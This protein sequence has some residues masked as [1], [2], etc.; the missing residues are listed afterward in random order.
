MYIPDSCQIMQVT[1]PVLTV[2]QIDFLVYNMTYF[3]YFVPPCI[4]KLYLL[5]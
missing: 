3:Y 4:P 2:L 5:Q 1:K